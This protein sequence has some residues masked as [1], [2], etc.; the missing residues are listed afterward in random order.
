MKNLFV[1]GISLYA[2][3]GAYAATASELDKTA[4]ADK[5]TYF[6]LQRMNLMSISVEFD[7]AGDN[8]LSLDTIKEANLVAYG[9]DTQF[10]EIYK[11]TRLN[12]DAIDALSEA[13]LNGTVSD[14]AKAARVNY[15]FRD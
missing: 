10:T 2:L 13:A 6:T 12:V 8:R 14:I 7:E 3:V 4:R 5:A 15:K 9:L 1:L 11:A